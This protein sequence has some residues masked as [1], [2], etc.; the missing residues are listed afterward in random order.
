[1]AV[2]EGQK[3]TWQ[4]TFSREDVEAFA[5][6]SGDRGSHHLRPDEAGRIMV[7]G[8]LTA[9][10]PTKI[11]GDLDYIAREMTFEFLRPVFVGDTV[12][13]DAVVTKVTHEA[14]HLAVAVAFECHNQDGKKVLSGSTHGIIRSTS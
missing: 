6:V 2:E 4:R 10:V 11:G 13:V 9:T 5:R 12:R 7:H 1:M 3:Y 8:L 14:G